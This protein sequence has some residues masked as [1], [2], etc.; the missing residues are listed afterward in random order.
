MISRILNV[1]NVVRHYLVME[2]YFP[3][4]NLRDMR[5]LSTIRYNIHDLERI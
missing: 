1:V 2:K 3:D 4:T 5:P